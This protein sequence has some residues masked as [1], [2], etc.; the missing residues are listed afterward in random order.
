M[1]ILDVTDA[2]EREITGSRNP[3]FER[4]G[5]LMQKLVQVPK[6]EVDAEA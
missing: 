6:A 5:H 2:D 4:T 3:E 1:D